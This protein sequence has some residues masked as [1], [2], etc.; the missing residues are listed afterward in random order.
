MK[1]HWTMHGVIRSRWGANALSDKRLTELRRAA[2]CLG[3]GA[4]PTEHGNR[5][6]TKHSKSCKTRLIKEG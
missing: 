3:C 5:I 2:A 6:V 1:A 4:S